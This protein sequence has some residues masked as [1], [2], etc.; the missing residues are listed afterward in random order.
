MPWPPRRNN[1]LKSDYALTIINIPT[2]THIFD[3]CAMISVGALYLQFTPTASCN[4]IQPLYRW[5]AWQAIRAREGG[6]KEHTNQVK[7]AE[8]NSIIYVSTILNIFCAAS[9]V[10]LLLT[11]ATFTPSIIPNL[12]LLRT[13]P[14]LTSVSNTLLAIWYSPILF[15]SP[16]HLNTLASTQL[17]NSLSISALL[18]L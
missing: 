7:V 8:W 17:T 2:L 11:K 12:G 5:Q 1:H 16:S 18:R 4:G 14:P 15:T 3:T 9:A 10:I 6:P 13:R